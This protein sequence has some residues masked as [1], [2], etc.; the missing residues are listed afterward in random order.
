VPSGSAAQ[1]QT[2]VIRAEPL[3]APFAKGQQVAL[4]RVR[5]ANQVVAEIPLLALET[6]E[7]AGIFGRAWDTI[8]L[9]F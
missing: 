6:V 1:L 3:I 4:L 5:N 8:W 9:W 2:E 7:Q